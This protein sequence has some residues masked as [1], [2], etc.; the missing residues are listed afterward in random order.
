MDDGDERV[1]I[2]HQGMKRDV[3]VSQ[4][5]WMSNTDSVIPPDY[6]IHHIDGDIHNNTWENLLCLHQYDH[7]KF[8]QGDFPESWDEE[9]I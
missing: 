1:S 6:E 9:F 5:V 2:N 8:H 3:N 7:R 4:L